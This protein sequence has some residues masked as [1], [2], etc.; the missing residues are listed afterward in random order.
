MFFY[1]AVLCYAHAC[2]IWNAQSATD[3]P[4]FSLQRTAARIDRA[5]GEKWKL[6]KVSPPEGLDLPRFFLHS[7]RLALWS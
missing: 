2:C 5:E 1:E 6:M 7:Y 3:P 4:T